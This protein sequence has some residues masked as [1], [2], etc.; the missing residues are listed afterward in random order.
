MKRY[1]RNQTVVD[2]Q[3]RSE[4][5]QSDNEKIG[6]FSLILLAVVIIYLIASKI[7]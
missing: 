5:Q 6:C 1:Y 7:F 3:G 2:F 4:R